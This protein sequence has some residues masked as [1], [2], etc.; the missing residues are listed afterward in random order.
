MY[1]TKPL[2]NY[3]QLSLLVIIKSNVSETF[4][5]T[6]KNNKPFKTLLFNEL[7]GFIVL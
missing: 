5:E 6:S 4:S 2:K 1:L 3:D 7:K